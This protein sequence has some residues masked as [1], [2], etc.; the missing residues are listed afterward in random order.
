M[1]TNDSEIGISH[2]HSRV[3]ENHHSH[4]VGEQNT[5][6]GG[7]VESTQESREGSQVGTRRR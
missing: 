5:G 7:E 3:R 4:E 1:N 6:S 2:R